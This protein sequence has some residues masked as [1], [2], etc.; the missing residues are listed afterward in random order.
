MKVLGACTLRVKNVS[1]G[2]V[3]E[4]STVSVAGVWTLRME[5]VW[6]MTTKTVNREHASELSGRIKGVCKQWIWRTG[7]QWSWWAFEQWRWQVGYVNSGSKACINGRGGLF[8]KTVHSGRLNGEGGGLVSSEGW[9]RLSSEGRQDT[10]SDVS[11]CSVCERYYAI[12][13]GHNGLSLARWCV[14]K[15]VLLE[16]F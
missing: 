10:M 12:M 6:T 5:G 2:R 8:A 14:D 3:A 4:V 13:N 7:G 16:C 15:P 1:V 11:L 9:R